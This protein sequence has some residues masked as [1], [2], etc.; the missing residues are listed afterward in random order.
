MKRLMA[1]TA[2]VLFV[3]FT[4]PSARAQGVMETPPVLT[5]LRYEISLAFASID[6]SLTDAVTKLSIT[7]T[8]GEEARKV[9]GQLCMAHPYAVDCAIVSSEGRM[10]MVEPQ[11]YRKFEGSDISKQEQVATLRKTKKPVLSDTFRS[12]EG[13]AAVDIEYPLFSRENKF[14]GSVSML[15]KPEVFLGSI[16]GAP[17]KGLPGDTFVMQRDGYILYDTGK[18][19][20]GKNTF[21]SP[22]YKSFPQLLA[23]G[24]RMTAERSGSGSYEFLEPGLKGPV[25]KLAHW[26]TVG[27]YG[28]EWRLVVTIP[29]RIPVASVI[30]LPHPRQSSV[31]SV[32]KALLERRSVR[33]YRGE[34]LVLSEVSQ[35]LWA[36]QGVTEQRK[37]LRTA[38]SAKAL[39]LL[40]TYLFS[41][42]VRGLAP[43]MYKYNPRGHELTKIADG[44]M[45]EKLYGAAGQAPIKQ[46]PAVILFTGEQKR[47]TNPNWIYLE[48]GHAA[49]N[50]YLQAYS[51][52]IGTVVMGEFKEEDVRKAL[53]LTDDE[54][55]IYIMPIGK[56]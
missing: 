49:Q 14:I 47:S 42:N 15:I 38:P 11:E 43:G 13:L 46:A 56:K 29:D 51:L 20:I 39:F 6:R 27:L 30:K 7:G 10:T 48:A 35:I 54:R 45:K 9:L 19:Q 40:D 23:L 53:N 8:E 31:T 50:V 44:N 4:T 17:T 55:P 21:D 2:L 26:V 28:G 5:K 3:V 18:E 34:P 37:G 25:K 32:E 41:G 52:G 36:A 22:L 24:K 16:M 12:V 1:L 33:S